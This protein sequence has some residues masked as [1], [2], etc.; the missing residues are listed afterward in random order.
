MDAS[1]VRST[2][3]SK[4]KVNCRSIDQYL[5]VTRPVAKVDWQSKRG[6]SEPQSTTPVAQKTSNFMTTNLTNWSQRWHANS[7]ADRSAGL[8][9]DATN[10]IRTISAAS[11]QGHCYHCCIRQRHPNHCC[12]S[13]TAHVH[14]III[15]SQKPDHN[16]YCPPTV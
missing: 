3:K 2:Q 8:A 9:K 10:S 6:C 4:D 11:Q 1:R 12:P 16:Q 15:A 13:A 5:R 7:N 14:T